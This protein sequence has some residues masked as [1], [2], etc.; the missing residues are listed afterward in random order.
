MELNIIFLDIDRVLCLNRQIHRDC[1]QN[2]KTI[3]DKTSARIIL[4]FSCKFFP[5]SHRQ[6]ESLFKD[7]GIDSILGWTSSRNKIL[8]DEVYF[9]LK[10]C[11]NT[12]TDDD[13]LIAKWI[14]IDDMHLSKLDSKQMQ[15]YFVLTKEEH[16]IMEETTRLLC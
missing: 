10:N 8:V 5:K 6:T 11:D 15:D 3:V 12:T 14:D 2:L 13:I 1:L 4:S 16:R 9:S 7:I